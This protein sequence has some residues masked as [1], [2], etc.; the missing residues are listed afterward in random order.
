MTNFSVSSRVACN[1]VLQSHCSRWRITIEY[2]KG[3][4][5]CFV[6]QQ[7]TT[8]SVARALRYDNNTVERESPR[9]ESLN[10]MTKTHTHTHRRELESQYIVIRWTQRERERG[11]GRERIPAV[12]AKVGRGK[13][14]KG[15]WGNV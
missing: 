7:D 10:S 12:A 14:M 1:F 15:R 13:M 3:T 2:G 9:M 4:R 5:S 8:L 11:G 6:V